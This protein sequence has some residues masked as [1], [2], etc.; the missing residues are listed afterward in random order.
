VRDRDSFVELIEAGRAHGAAG[1]PDDALSAFER[2]V[3]LDPG[4]VEA[5]VGVANAF[6]ALRRYRQ[7]IAAARRVLA[8]EPTNADARFCLAVNLSYVDGFEE[9]EPVIEALI[10]ERPDDIAT[11][12]AAGK[13]AL[14]LRHHERGL[15]HFARAK[16]LAGEFKPLH[17]TI[18]QILSELGTPE[19]AQG[20]FD[21]MLARWPDDDGIVFSV[22]HRRMLACDWRGFDAMTRLMAERLDGAVAANRVDPDMLWTLTNHGFG[23]G[24]TMKVARKLAARVI[25]RVPASARLVLAPRAPRNKLRIG[26]IQAMTTFHSTQIAIRNVVERMD[27]GRFEVIGYAR[28]DRPGSGEFQDRFRS[29][30]DRFVDLTPMS[31]AQAAARIAADDIDILIDMQG[32]N[33]LNNLGV[34]AY[35]PARLLALYYG[36]S[37]GA[38]GGVYDYYL[39]DRNYLPAELAP[40][41]GEKVVYLPGC[42]L[43]P[44]LGEIPPGRAR[45]ADYDLPEDAFVLCNFNHNWKFDPLCFALWM[46]ILRNVPVAVL[47]LLEWRRDAADY[48]RQEAVRAGV[49]PRRL[50]F[51]KLEPFAGHL[52]RL[53]LAD[54]AVNGVFVGGGVTSLDALW[55]GVPMVAL[56]GAADVLWSRLGGVMLKSAGMPEFV[57]GSIEAMERGILELARHPERLL[58]AR[59]KLDALRGTCDLFDLDRATRKIESACEA[60]WDIHLRGEAPRDIALDL[61]QP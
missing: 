42:H 11:L 3:E 51:A 30:F 46:R 27:R 28:H 45:R 1:R 26:F 50:I 14:A 56:E 58:A 48:L 36:F 22:A 34:L 38:G 49:D 9:A 16:V 7:A 4:S 33:A 5:L 53:T 40:E 2:A 43:V 13:I 39:T 44:T 60:M 61:D 19:D 52:K 10:A 25:A 17:L 18:A 55:A 15:G 24:D 35:R 23:Y 47:W 20:A 41:T 8:L 32:L 57:F 59:A 6:A 12:V 31:D 29:A 54:L 21:E 37:H